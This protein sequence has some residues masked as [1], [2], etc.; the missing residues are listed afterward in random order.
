MAAE[1]RDY[2]SFKHRE[3]LKTAVIQTLAN[4]GIS[5]LSGFNDQDQNQFW[6]KK[7]RRHC[8]DTGRVFGLSLED[9]RQ[10]RVVTEVS[11][12]PCYLPK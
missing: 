11:G 12:R 1:H 2:F 5:S 4:S 3:S 6:D 10:D 7:K 9:E 8:S